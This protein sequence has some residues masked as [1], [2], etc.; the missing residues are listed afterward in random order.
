MNFYQGSNCNIE[1]LVKSPKCST[2][3]PQNEQRLQQRSER[4]S[5]S[6][7][8]NFTREDQSRKMK[9]KPSHR[10]RIKTIPSREQLKTSNT[11]KTN[12]DDNVPLPLQESKKIFSTRPNRNPESTTLDNDM[13]STPHDNKIRTES[14]ISEI[15]KKKSG[16]KGESFEVI[17]EDLSSTRGETSEEIQN[18]LSTTQGE[19]SKVIQNIV[20]GT[21]REVSDAIKRPLDDT[22]IGTSE[23]S[24]KKPQE[25]N[26]KTSQE[27]SGNQVNPNQRLS[28]DV[29]GSNETSI[30]AQQE[31]SSINPYQ[32]HPNQIPKS[33][34]ETTPQ[35]PLISSFDLNTQNVYKS[36]TDERNTPIGKDS[37]EVRLAKES[38]QLS[39]RPETLPINN[40]EVKSRNKVKDD[41]DG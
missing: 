21:K 26:P 27:Q 1:S 4:I 2:E 14:A 34:P 28:E 36:I 18:N 19:A 30:S 9:S 40:K 6:P 13:S 15:R 24:S 33:I 17:Q 12:S 7:Q 35:T 11:R 37:S 3:F 29:I 20:D 39:S 32:N 5:L 25:T 23:T 41:R 10:T 22:K 16:T 38:L 31:K 8:N